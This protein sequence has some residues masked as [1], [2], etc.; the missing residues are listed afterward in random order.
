MLRFL[1]RIQA[2]LKHP[3]RTVGIV[4]LG[5][6]ALFVI[7]DLGHRFA[8]QRGIGEY[9]LHPGVRIERLALLHAE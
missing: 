5:H 1:A 7:V 9:L 2:Q 4:S 6:E 3:L 8:D